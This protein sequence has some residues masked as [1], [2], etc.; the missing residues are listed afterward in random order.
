MRSNILNYIR[1]QRIIL[2]LISMAFIMGTMLSFGIGSAA[3]A[4]IYINVMA[5]NGASDPKNYSI[6]FNLPGE[7]AAEDIM[8][9]NGL[10]LD[11]SVDDADYFVYGDVTLKPKE[12][13]TF[14]I[15]VK[16]KW[17]V[18]GPQVDDLKKQIEQGYE[19]L[20]KPYDASKA[21]ILK[22]RLEK[23][24]DYIVNLQSTN[25][26]SIDKRIDDYR[27]YVKEIKRIQNDAINRDYWRSDPSD[28]SEERRVGK[29]CRSRWSPY[30]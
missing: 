16:D 6:K 23:K 21:Q 25:A 3:Y 10:Q 12:I 19:I 13:K 22:E 15:H 9:T 18:T 27:V 1:P 14:R 4:D 5:V 24:I 20:G 11:Y 28:R 30:H 2:K 29:E 8:D 17:M 26:G 7:L